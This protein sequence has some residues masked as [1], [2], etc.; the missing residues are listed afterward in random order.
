LPRAEHSRY[1]QQDPEPVE[2]D[3][4]PVHQAEP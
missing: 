4:F 1:E 2:V 3:G